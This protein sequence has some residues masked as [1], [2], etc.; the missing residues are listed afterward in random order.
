MNSVNFLKM[1]LSYAYNLKHFVTVSLHASYKAPDK[2]RGGREKLRVQGGS[3]LN[4]YDCIFAA[5]P[6]EPTFHLHPR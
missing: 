3:H 6:P 5:W 4:R 1:F 2:D